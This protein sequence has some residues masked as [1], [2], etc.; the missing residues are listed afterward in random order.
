MKVA[1]ETTIFII[2]IP[3]LAQVICNKRVL[4][5]DTI[6]IEERSRRERVRER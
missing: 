2:K 5:L 1:R 4:C 6:I 3:P